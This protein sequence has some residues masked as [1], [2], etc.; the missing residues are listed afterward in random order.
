MAE[1]FIK[2]IYHEPE[3]ADLTGLNFTV[4]YDQGTALVS[5]QEM[6]PVPFQDK[7]AAYQFTL[8]MLAE[9]LRKAAHDPQSIH[10]T[11]ERVG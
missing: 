8:E 9:A 10:E 3:S 1:V 5:V 11:P 4:K 2:A 6:K 7:L